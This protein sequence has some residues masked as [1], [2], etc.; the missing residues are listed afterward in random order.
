[1]STSAFEQ[2]YRL[3]DV[4]TSATREEI[5]RAYLLLVNVWHPDRFR[6]NPD[7][8]A[9]AQEKLQ[10]INAAYDAIR[11][12]PLAGVTPSWRGGEA[13][14]SRRSTPSGPG[15]ERTALEWASLGRRLTADPGWLLSEGEGLEWNDIA[16]LNQF[17]EG[18][19][20]LR[21]ATELDPG[22]VEAWHGLGLAHL[23]L[24]EQEQAIEAFQK[25]VSLDRDHVDSW[26]GLGSACAER[27]RHAR[28][29]SAFSE[30]VRLRPPDA[31]AW[32]AL[33]SARIRTNEIEEAVDAFRRSLDLD[34]DRAEAWYALGAAR[35]FPGP[36]GRV[37][38]EEALAAFRR[39]VELRP[40]MAEGW[41]G[42]GTTLSGLGRHQEAVP[43]LQQ[44][45][46]LRPDSAE[47]WYSLAVA[48]RYAPSASGARGLREAYTRLKRLAPDEA[49]RLRQLLP[50]SMRL[51]LLVFERLK[52]GGAPARG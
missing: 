48:K 15:A 14:S 28:A 47:S 29:A 49:S 13:V 40:E 5:H 16:N 21:T 1:M 4:D 8:Q 27:G 44:A 6:H 2:S 18:V 38:P 36:D 17:L 32:Y 37:E 26:I 34:P 35:A 43:A 42:L 20:A 19:R 11:E 10:A 46:S 51:S 3:L 24:G 23:A 9:K 30:V 41:H 31:A 45:V 50:Y 39:A 12:A 22:L 25:A 33:G 7:L 52:G